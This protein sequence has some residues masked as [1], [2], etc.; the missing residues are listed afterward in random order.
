M[1]HPSTERLIKKLAD[2]TL[3]NRVNW[4]LGDNDE[5]YHDTEGYRI[6]IDSNPL[7]ILIT[8]TSAREIEALSYED[9]FSP[10][11]GQPRETQELNSDQRDATEHPSQTPDTEVPPTTYDVNPN[12][13]L[14]EILDSINGLDFFSLPDTEQAQIVSTL[15]NASAGELV[16]FIYKLGREFATQDFDRDEQPAPISELRAI[17]SGTVIAELL[18]EDLPIEVPNEPQFTETLPTTY[19]PDPPQPIIIRDAAYLHGAL[20]RRVDILISELEGETSATFQGF[21]GL[22][23]QA[24]VYRD[25]LGESVTDT[26]MTAVYTE[27]RT[28]T[29]FLKADEDIESLPE[30]LKDFEKPILPKH[31]KGILS[32]LVATH[33]DFIQNNLNADNYTDLNDDD[34]EI[35]RQDVR[36]TSEAEALVRNLRNSDDLI[37]EDALK[38]VRDRTASAHTA[39]QSDPHLAG[40][41]ITSLKSTLHNLATA[42]S[43]FALKRLE[44]LGIAI[45]EAERSAWI[46]A[47]GIVSVSALNNLKH[48]IELVRNIAQTLNSIELGPVVRFLTEILLRAA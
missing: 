43:K 31:V 30:N 40:R 11:P 13:A 36:F 41:Q 3:R 7:E 1:I 24:M 48:A 17:P 2:M 45:R 35:T 5:I 47:G 20:A 18:D 42:L 9:L 22:F 26:Y 29:A 46:F 44:Q 28:L 4:D 6:R 19:I 32:D 21:S 16:Y 15:Q 12:S 33:D 38:L 25:Y 27:G 34:E 23:R 10:V 8:D 14:Q 37:S 39:V